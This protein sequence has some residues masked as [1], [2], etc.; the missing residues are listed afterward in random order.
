VLSPIDP[1]AP[2]TTTRLRFIFS[3]ELTESTKWL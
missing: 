2:K 3:T 1:V